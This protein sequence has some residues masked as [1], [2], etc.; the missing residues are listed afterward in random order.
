[1]TPRDSQAALQAALIVHPQLLRR[2]A[3]MHLLRQRGFTRVHEA[4][5]GQDAA[6][7]I[8]HERVD[9]VFTP[10]SAGQLTGQALFAALKAR[11]RKAAPAIVVLDEGLPQATVVAAVKAGAAGRL[12]LPADET[13][14]GR[15][16]A[17]LDEAGDAPI[18]ATALRQAGPSD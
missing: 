12:V 1:L 4:E 9:V 2:R 14:L 8:K 18:A 15:V 3:L 7:L 16:L 13:S 5:D 6:T 11:G 17:A 10:W